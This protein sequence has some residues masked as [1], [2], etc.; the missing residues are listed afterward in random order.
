MSISVGAYVRSLALLATVR[1]RMEG[2]D[3][4]AAGVAV[5]ELQEHWWPSTPWRWR[6]RTA[7]GR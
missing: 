3:P 6:I 2:L 1:Q 5:A 4:V 7:G